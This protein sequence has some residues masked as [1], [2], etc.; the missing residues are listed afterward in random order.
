ISFI[1][2]GMT[3]FLTAEWKHLAMLNYAIEP[4]I[5][6]PL[7]PAGTELDAWNG[8][9]YISIVGF[10]FADTRVSG[11]AI[12]FHRNF[13]EVNLRFYVRRKCSDG[14]KR[15]VVFIKEIVPRS[16]IALVARYAYNE[17]YIGLPMSHQIEIRSG[18]LHAVQYNW[19][20]GGRLNSLAVVVRGGPQPLR[21]GS[22]AEFITKHYWGYNRQRDG[23]TLECQV[24][25]PRWRYYDVSEA[26]LQCEVGGLYGSQYQ[27]S[28][29]RGPV[30]VFLAEGSA[31]TVHRGVKFMN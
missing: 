5:L 25:H 20:F 27:A 4:S 12:P 14:W 8:T 21:V 15:G 22:E 23:S 17:P 13:E 16:M 11:H 28:M 24:E 6:A 29:N 7:V 30:S 10:L 31:I 19:R 18:A 26:S 9:H 3:S 2:P 1:L